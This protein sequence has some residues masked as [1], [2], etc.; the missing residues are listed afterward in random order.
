MGK[1]LT[2]ALV[3]L[4][5][6]GAGAKAFA[7]GET[8]HNVIGRGCL[9]KHVGEFVDQ[10]APKQLDAKCVDALG[11]TPAFIGFNGSSP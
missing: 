1:Q 4:M 6:V 10:L 9:P 11:P 7:W 5:Q 2:W 8:G 3:A